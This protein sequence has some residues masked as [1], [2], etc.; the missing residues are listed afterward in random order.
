MHFGV[1]DFIKSK[2]FILSECVALL[3]RCEPTHQWESSCVTLNAHTHTPPGLNYGWLILKL[4]KANPD[5]EL[6]GCVQTWEKPTG[7]G[8]RGDG[9][10]IFSFQRWYSSVEFPAWAH[11][12]CPSLLSDASQTSVSHFHMLGPFYAIFWD[13]PSHLCASR[14]HSLQIGS[15][16]ESSIIGC[17][18]KDL[19]NYNLLLGYR[20][21]VS[22]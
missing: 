5:A 22:M 6:S 12:A 1:L 4:L 21:P 17:L 11:L 2:R 3:S 10:T 16:M 20:K 13:I 18:N 9:K 14:S 19:T 7:P 15:F 8:V